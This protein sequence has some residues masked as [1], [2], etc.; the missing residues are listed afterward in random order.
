MGIRRAAALFVLLAVVHTWPLSSAPWRQSLNYHADAQ[1]NAWIV[2][3]IAHTLPVR[4]LHLFD[5]NIFAPE[6]GTLAYSEPLIAPALVAAPVRWLGGSPVLAFNL[7]TIAGLAL[8]AW[9]AWFVAWRWTGSPSAALVAGALAA[10]NVHVLTRLAHP[11]ATQA[12]SL[13]LVWY[14]ADAAIDRGHRRDAAALALAI[15]ATAATSIYLLAFAGVIVLMVALIGARRPSSIVAIAGACAAGL[16]AS[17]PVLW[18]YVQ[19]AASG[20]TRPIE[21]VAQFSASPAGYLASTSRLEAPMTQRFFTNDVNVMFA[22][23][24]ALSLAALGLVTMARADSRSRR[25]LVTVILVALAGI[26]LSFGPATMIYR[27]LYAWVPPLRGLRAAA[28]FGYLYLLAVAFLAAYGLAWLQRRV[29]SRRRVAMAIVTGV[30]VLVGVEAWQGPV[31]TVPFNGVPPIY[32]LLAEAP[33]PVQLVEVPFYPPEA[34]FENGEYVFNSTAHWQP[35]MNG[36]SGFTPDSYRRRAASFWSFPEAWAIDAIKREGATHIMVHL[37][38]FTPEE[39]ATIERVLLDRH[40][41]QL[42]AGD[43]LGNRLYRVVQ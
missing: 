20:N 10:F 13:P 4:P 31:R 15:A 39:A 42:V 22:G 33:A 36:Y 7:L 12:W 34:V 6:R 17:A 2:S 35:L 1:L 32:S 28:R 8:T 23:V 37:K 27:W 19:L 11:A 29:E 3:W 43:P 30:M 40:D 9:S 18:P 24:T 14:F 41:L 38:R 21:M 16:L 26:V 5:A 25:R